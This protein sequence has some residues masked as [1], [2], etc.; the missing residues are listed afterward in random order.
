MFHLLGLRR[1]WARSE[2]SRLPPAADVGDLE[3]R[4]YL[5]V[6]HGLALLLAQC[7]PR[8]ARRQFPAALQAYRDLRM[9]I[10]RRRPLHLP[11]H[12]LS[13]LGHEIASYADRATLVA[14]LNCLRRQSPRAQVLRL[15]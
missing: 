10:R 3:R 11:A 12:L 15:A 5:L 9:Q 6:A 1:R 4:D 2:F 7:T 13:D 14:A 8:G